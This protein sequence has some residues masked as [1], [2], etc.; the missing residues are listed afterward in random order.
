MTIIDRRIVAAATGQLG[1]LSRQRAHDACI[2]DK[3]LRSRVS[4]GFLRQTGPHTFELA[5]SPRTPEA[6]LR[7]LIADLGDEAFACGPTAAALHGFDGFRL[8]PPFDVVVTR[9]RNMRRIGHRVHTTTRLDLIDRT[10]VGGVPAISGARTLIDLARVESVEGLRIAYDSGLRD[11]RFNESLLHRRIVTLRSSGRYGMP[12]LLA[13]IE[14]AEIVS[15]AHSWLERT[16]LHIMAEAG[17]PRPETQVVL[18]RAQDRLVR[19]DFRFSISAVVVEVLGYRY[20]RTPE[21]L[22]RDTSRMNALL[23]DGYRP[24]QFTYDQ[25]VDEPQS[26]VA[27]VSAALRSPPTFV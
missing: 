25:I 17:L 8:R 6:E 1:I 9:G 12:K 21:Q 7:A 26:V 14:G 3:Q 2:T 19:V 5:G 22:R 4:S 24:Y 27:E 20:H 16:F 10:L 18:S 23:T 15:G 11:G 13:A